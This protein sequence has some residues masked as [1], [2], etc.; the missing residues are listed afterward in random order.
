[1]KKH[2]LQIDVFSATPLLG[3]PAAVVYDADDLPAD[4]MQRIAREMNLSETVFL[5]RPTRQADY[6]ARIFTPLNE[7]P[8]AGHPTIAAAH[9]ICARMEREPKHLIQ[10]CGLGLVPIRIADGRYTMTQATP[11]FRPADIPKADL[12][13]ALALPP[14]ALADSPHETVSTGAPWLLLELRDAAALRTLRP[15]LAQI[16]RLSRTAGAAGLTVFA[17]F[18]PGASPRLR[19]RTFAPGE[20]VAEDPVCGSGNGAIAAWIATHRDRTFSGAY[21][22]EQGVE[23]GRR[24]LVHAAWRARPEGLEISIGGAACTLLAG[25]IDLT[26]L[27]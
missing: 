19:V 21:I 13:R 3:N 11:T 27:L 20:G 12:A 6:R 14:E 5:L 25:E 26:G 22:A 7:L 4:T 10:E 15:D 16:E 8:F 23:I 17:D 9:A 1:M 24:G 2:I 18:G